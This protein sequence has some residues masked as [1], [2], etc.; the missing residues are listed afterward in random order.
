MAD[1]LDRTATLDRAGIGS[2]GAPAVPGVAL[3]AAG[4][5]VAVIWV[6]AGGM[7]VA[8]P[9]P[10][11]IDRGWDALIGA[12][13]HSIAHGIAEGFAVVGAGLP[14]VLVA[15]VVAAIVG[16]LRGW[17]WGAFVVVASLASELDVLGL[18]TLAA[19][20]RPEIAFG[21]GTSF[22]S[23]HTANAAL[24]GTVV[25]LLFR[26]L[27]VRIPVVLVVVAMAWSRTAIHA[28]W[29]TDV[30]GGLAIGSA[31]GV[32]LC[33][34]W[35]AMLARRRLRLERAERAARRRALAA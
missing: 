10:G 15:V 31:T 6:I 13:G 29:L 7:R 30:L 21:I 1:R 9:H 20:A 17:A 4:A 34:A 35:A 8:A 23:G 14:A 25:V 26:Q 32:L 2:I 33:G 5:V 22:P 24:L 16:A 19:R 11:L 18:K 27:A 28:H 3:A 12:D